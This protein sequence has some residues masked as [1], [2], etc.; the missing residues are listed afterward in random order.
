VLPVTLSRS[1]L[2]STRAAIPFLK[3]R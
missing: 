2:D 1:E 3:D